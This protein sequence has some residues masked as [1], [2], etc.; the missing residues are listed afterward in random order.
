MES[1]SQ[2]SSE[3]RSI[4]GIIKNELT[5][6]NFVSVLRPVIAF[7]GLIIFIDKPIYLSLFLIIAFLTDAIDGALAKHH[8]RKM[9]HDL[10]SHL[11]GYI[12][13]A[14]DRVLQL[15]A[16]WF[17]YSYNMVPFIIPFIFTVKDTIFDPTRVYLDLKKKELNNI[18]GQYNKRHP[19]QTLIH[20]IYE[21][22]FICGVPFFGKTV[23]LIL[24]LGLAAF[25]I[26]RGLA[27]ILY[28]KMR[29]TNSI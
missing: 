12:D 23:I 14:A 8:N 13:L 21:G 7:Y 10:Q 17:Y 28:A 1:T 22:V 2:K 25:G 11:G 26:Y 16:L 9:P 19:R 20:G 6:A 4:A 29:V 18:L 27:S 3:A 5:L 15:G 24:G